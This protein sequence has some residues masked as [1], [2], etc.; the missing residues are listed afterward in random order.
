MSK[1]KHW[2][3]GNYVEIPI[4]NNRYCYGV[5]TITG[6]LAVMDYCDSNHLTPTEISELS[7][8]FEVGVMKYGIG[9]NGWALAGKVELNE[10]FSKY[11][12]FSKKDPINGKLSIVDH[13]FMNEIPATEAECNLLEKAAV[14]DPCHIEERLNEHYGLH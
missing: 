7:V 8:L 5:V 12:M 6:N 9:K 13:T 14:W 11:P 10:K 4:S 1:L 2:T 3:H